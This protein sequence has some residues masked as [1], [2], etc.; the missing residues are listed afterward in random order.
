ML[1][2]VF[3]GVLII[4]LALGNAF[5]S[6]APKKKAANGFGVQ[7]QDI[8]NGLLPSNE[9]AFPG[10]SSGAKLPAP[11]QR[12]TAFEKEL[13]REKI[14]FLGKRMARLEQLLLKM[15]SNGFLAQKLD[16]SNLGQRLKSLE[17]FKEKTRLE[18]AA[19][20]QRLDNSVP[21]EKRQVEAIPAV[22]NEKLHSLVFRSGR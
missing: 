14:A 2:T 10:Q 18:V 6:L 16:N 12:A 4:A 11:S 19:L 22:S 13:E 15:N 1:E 21:A 7:G 5:L 9:T 17:E 20:K 8:N 3:L